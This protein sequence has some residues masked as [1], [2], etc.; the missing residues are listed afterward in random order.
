MSAIKY[1]RVLE[2]T[3]AALERD[4]KCMRNLMKSSSKTLGND[5]L[6]KRLRLKLNVANVV[7]DH[8][9]GMQFVEQVCAILEQASLGKRNYKRK[10]AKNVVW[11]EKSGRLRALRRA[12]KLWVWAKDSGR[13]SAA[14]PTT[15]SACRIRRR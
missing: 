1:Y 5:E 11:G 10:R 15:T 13:R 14:P 8:A 7:T 4:F 6:G 2:K 12:L 9:P 3:S